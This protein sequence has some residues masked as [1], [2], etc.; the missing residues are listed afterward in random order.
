[1]TT[2]ELPTWSI[3]VIG[4]PAPQGSKRAFPNPKNPR[5]PI[6]VD[7]NP[8]T[9]KPW[10]DAVAAAC[11][12]AI[13]EDASGWTIAGPCRLTIDFVFAPVASA[14]DRVAHTT[15]PD[16]DK[17]VR[18]TLDALKNG[19]A[20]TDDSLACQLV[21][22]KRYADGTEPEGALI[23]LA[24]LTEQNAAAMERR[25]ARRKAAAK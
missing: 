2:E 9:L 1:M 21:I 3:R 24:D 22:R 14:P 4:T 19:R 17:L 12:K 10:R 13:D 18:S 8:K 20:F 25:K 7:D 16:V 23:E 11:A 5:M 6:V 15:R